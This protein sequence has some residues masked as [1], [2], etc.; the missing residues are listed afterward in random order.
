MA[1]AKCLD[2]T[3]AVWRSFIDHGGL[4]AKVL[5]NMSIISATPG[6]LKC[7]M[8]IEKHHVNRYNTLHGGT[9]ATM[10]D[11]GGTLAVA[12]RGLWTTGVSTDINITYISSGGTI[13]D[14]ITMEGEVVRLGKTLAFT[15]VFF[16]NAKGEM[17]AKGNHTKFVAKCW[18]DERNKV[19]ELHAEEEPAGK[20]V[21]SVAG[22]THSL[23]LPSIDG[24]RPLRIMSAMQPLP[25]VL[26]PKLFSDLKSKNEDARQ[27][28]AGELRDYVAA[29]SRE[30]SGE[31]LTRFNNDINRRIF[32][33]IHSN[34]VNEK[35][36]GILAIDRLIDYEGEEN[37]TKITR[38]AN[39][40]R[41]VL[42]GN[43]TQAMILASKALGRLAV[44]GGTLTAEFV[45]F[46]V[47]KALEWLQGDRHEARRHAAVL[48]L[49]ELAIN[50]PTLIYSYVPQILDLIWVALRDPKVIIRDSAAD[51]LS[52]CLEIIYQRESQLRLQWYTK[53]LEEA[54][55][56]LRLNTA[57][58]IHASLLT[59]RELLLR[60]GMF[61]HER[62]RE[63][64]EIV[65]RY[66][67]H[68]DALIR[69]SV[70]SLIPTLAA[71]NPNE[72]VAS[73]LHKCMLHL[74]GLL[75][76]EKDR[77]AP[78]DAVG[79]VAIAVGSS[80][81]PYLD[82][83]L[84]SIKEGL[85]MKG[86]TRATQEAPIFQCISMLATAVGQAL[87]KHIHEL[88]DLMFACGLSEPLR[89]A[90]V[91]LAHYIPPL[92]PTIQERLLNMLSM[93]LS[94]KPFKQP[95]SPA[96]IQTVIAPAVAR[97][98]RESQASEG[99]DRELITLALNTLGTFDFSGHVLN[100]FV[101]D[102]AI[103]Y[104]EDDN[105]EVR[106]AAAL[107]CCQ[108]FV[109]DPI[110][111]QTSNHAIQ[112][113]GEV[114]E[115][116][117]TVGI[118]D[119]DPVIR[120][121]VLS[122]LDERFDRHLA[123]AEN[124]RS[125]FIALNDE[126]FAIRELAITII[127]R[128]TFHNP[129]YVMPSLRKTLISLLTELEYSSVSRNKEEAARLLSLLVA[130]SQKLIKPYVEPMLKVLLPK[131]RDA[132]SGVA[133]SVLSALG[134]LAN[135]GGEDLLV[136]IKD[137]MPLI[138]DTLHDQSSSVKRDAALKAL[139]Q[140]A[141]SSGYVIDP[142]LEYPQLLNILIGILKTEQSSDIRRETVK[143]MGILGALDPYRHQ[144]IERG[145]EEHT[146][147]QKSVS[148]DVSLLM[149]GMTP[150]SEE[151]YPTVVISSLMNILKDPSLGAHHTAVIQAIMYIFKTMGLKCVPFLSQIIPGFLHVMRT[152]SP[153]IL[154]FY[155]QQLGIL[156]SI[157]KQHIRNFLE[158]IFKV[159]QEFWNPSSNLQITILALVE[160]IAR[161]L[162][163]EFKVYLPI[164]LPLM[165]QI[166][167]VDVTPSRQPTQKVLHAFIVFGQNIE[168]YM[169]LILPVVVK[170]FEKVDAP[171]T[172]RKAA[173]QTVAQLSRK[174]NFSDHASRIIHPLS[175]VLSTAN[176]ELKMA[177]MD[178][179]CAMIF[180]LGFDY[181][182]FIPMINKVIVT[183]KIQHPTYE[184]LVSKLL[185]GDALPQDLSPEERYGD[186]R[187]D[188]VS[189]ADISAKKLPV[190]QQHLKS[191]WEASQRSTRDD[192]QEWI[193][194]LSVELLKESPSHALRA[195][196]GLAGV[197]Y[198]LAREL[199]NA[200]FVSCWTELYDQYQDELVR[201]IETALISPNIPPEILQT[202][203][204]LA[205]FMEHDDKAL[206]I[207]IRTLGLYASKCHAFA[208][209]LHYKELEFI[210]E[211]STDTIEALISINNQLQQPDA[212]IGI[213]SHAQHHHDL[214]LKETWYE[215]LQRWEDALSAY[216]RREDQNSFDVTMGKMRCLHALGEWDLLSQLAQ[217]KW[218]HAGHDMRRAIA[219]L[220]AAAA[221]GMGQ[222][223][224]MDDYISVMKHES[225]D[226]AFFRAI[227]SLHRNQF[228]D[229][230]LHITKARD[231][232]DTELT[233]LVG[234][235]Y[236]RAYSVAVRVQMLAEL[237]EIISYKQNGDMPEKQATQRK[238]WMK[239][240]KGCQR[241]V[242]VWQR[243]LKVR[244]L[245]ISPKENME[246]WIKFA[247]L[248]RKSGRL[249]L[250][251]KSLNSL[252]DEE[253]SISDMSS[254][255]RAPPSVVYAHLK[256]TWATGGRREALHNLREFTA[257][258]SHDLGL[259]ASESYPKAL[260][261]DQAGQNIESYTRLLARCYL[262]QGEWQVAL[263]DRWNEQTIPDI[264]RSY[265]LATHF[266][267]DWYKAW[268]A[269]ALA[270]FEVINHHEL[271][272]N[273][274]TNDI[275][276]AHII[277][278][279]RGFF[280]SIALSKGNS[281]QDTLRLLT[282]WFKFGNNQDINN[283]ITEGFT[284]VRIDTWLEVIPQL[285]ARIHVTGPLVRRL[286]HQLLSDVGRAHPQALVYPVTVA[287]KSQSVSRQRA[288][289]AIMDNMRNHSAILVEQA[290]LVS[291]EL[292]RVAI[293]W[294]EQWHE[295]LEEASRLYFGDH[296]IQ[297]MFATLEPLHEMLERG[298]ETLRE[299]SFHQA[300]GRDLQEARDW[301][302]K[303]KRSGEPTDLNQAWDLYYQVFRK[304][305]KQLPQLTTLELQYV[306]PQLLAAR[307]LDLAVPGTYQSGKP[308]VKIS[309]FAPTFTVIT[310]KQR[311][312]RLTMKGSDGKDYQYAL[313]GHEDIRQDERVMQL[314]GLV[315][316]LLSID[317]ESFK[318]HLNIQR[319]PVIPLSPNS[320]LLG[321]V[322]DSDTLHVLI[323]DYRES[324]KI[325]LNIEHRLMLQMAP[326][327][328]N[329]MLMQ[330]VEVFEYALDNTTGQDLYRVLWLKSRS[331]EAWLDRRTNYTRSL[332]V[333]SMVGYILGL[334]DRHPSN[335][336]LDRFTGK[337]IHIDFGDC[338]EVAMHREKFPEKIPFRLTRMLVNAME[339]SGI[340]GSFRITCE[341]VMRVLRDN[342]E[343][344]MA[345]LEAFVYDPLINWR[346]MT[347][348]SPPESQVGEKQKL[349][350]PED[351]SR[352]PARRSKA[353]ESELVSQQ[354]NKP[355]VLNQRAVS[356]LNR[357]SNKLTGR[358]FKPNQELD[359][360]EQVERLIQQATSLENLCQLYIGWC[361]FW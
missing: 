286:I 296:N 127:G 92:L 158:D 339:V 209:A 300:F 80:M 258:M 317:S 161:A 70:I 271:K 76:K 78:F 295:G 204:N 242:E 22:E 58:T 36:G 294:H 69:R 270:N 73:Y 111:Y 55:H 37:T 278:A 10:V 213:L 12:T 323:R 199:F 325:L 192:W 88:L 48:V 211:P 27:R 202:L 98:I 329:L 135:V 298:P 336:M 222:W 129:A 214:E 191:A 110:C 24:E 124:V 39:Y 345:V 62:Y 355:E 115:R 217:D 102:C 220:A 66:K 322:P 113:V 200:A 128:L 215:K 221:W 254:A 288:A 203:L 342:K 133:S 276:T 193:R 218:I 2:F 320:G 162:E 134:E 6:K 180:Q 103:S 13:G 75:K 121:I 346:L 225:P 341:H 277:P 208:K 85:A 241:N 331:S 114:L 106:K 130:A 18:T 170:M 326:D 112:V 321:W 311:P 150:S 35:I 21:V 238:T 267:P 138:I 167:D 63:V 234:E 29:T 275:I 183:N 105:A 126:V 46:E 177:S 166:F 47:K 227:I 160:S 41:I 28:S 172:L 279:V 256:F 338:F 32:E 141:S 244:A 231:L 328:D 157:V 4:D 356:V 223:E 19:E 99:R 31:A 357:V 173:I 84:A 44:P 107:T 79:R 33:L 333:M 207:D 361:A 315:N 146:L 71:Y 118:A 175:R 23:L 125:L 87:T 179:L 316:T 197:Y 245:V 252:L 154:E 351:P 178:T 265:L 313:K 283:A 30:L 57:D 43:D 184:L 122:S 59:Y 169:H 307:D 83:I 90:L 358:D 147:E 149:V 233:A 282:L 293:L 248:C 257:K 291:K 330:K 305:S 206:P 11:L 96:H 132:S 60:A 343:S 20:T 164:L 287:S 26:L 360:R 347:N 38:F 186:A 318:R 281:L 340:E 306:S 337:V 17:F 237:E 3:K 230:A 250:A 188:E 349:D 67:D 131:A 210:S 262:K 251:E 334:G 327:Y 49:R 332:A 195:C 324:R 269:W 139:G 15:S 74:L 8:Q 64:C 174:V 243:M 159:I 1:S 264:L 226:R 359:V 9:I 260:T 120:Q 310:S 212:A 152:C 155:F 259:N 68:R 56:G 280:R 292:I 261:H 176:H 301:C 151:Y 187:T 297:A 168:E 16:M 53:I 153:T 42:P 308:I 116:L 344:L 196:A 104:V 273:A 91:D 274:I 194:R 50:S 65:L 108:L 137:L 235:S 34:D 86:K 205:E 289:L 72:F 144:I 40:L 5:A 268:H 253:E 14:T 148:T 61:M 354:Q 45:E 51:A 314:F 239:R 189:S 136:Y 100:E 272:E 224:L 54:Q 143:L 263:Q 185:K 163:G 352:A 228:T 52:A 165:L 236:N 109:R 290:L 335:L 156:V 81:G 190:N 89:Q 229:A 304:I 94:G 198:P 25:D 117:L 95:G 171:V 201:A 7:Q 247:N 240:L 353:D 266:D 312:R 299:I 216:E 285:I 123:Q 77:T 119:P 219:P 303:Y 249:G 232:L 182:I 82:A 97:E 181:A 350:N 145:T 255:I 309:S 302:S 140:L 101:K 319:Y 284:S 142:Y 246:M 348:V 93:I